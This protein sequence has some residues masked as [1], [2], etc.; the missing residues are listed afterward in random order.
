VIAV[1][2]RFG[3]ELRR[4]FARFRT[5]VDAHRAKVGSEHGFN[6]APYIWTER[7][8]GIRRA[9]NSSRDA[10]SSARDSLAGV[11][12]DHWLF[13]FFL[14]L[15]AGRAGLAAGALSLNNFLG[16]RIACLSELA[17]CRAVHRALSDG[18]GL[19]FERIARLIDEQLCLHSGR[20]FLS[21]RHQ[22]TRVRRWRSVCP[23]LQKEGQA[24]GL[25]G[26]RLARQLSPRV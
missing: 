1:S 21:E 24:R 9:Q 8:T 23:P 11:P 3:V 2:K 20:L 16:Y 5:G 15:L 17:G 19:L 25:P 14:A 10:T 13:L 26:F 12:L 18:I 22:L 6:P 7:P 4:G